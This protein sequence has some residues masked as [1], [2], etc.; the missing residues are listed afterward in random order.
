MASSIAHPSRPRQ[1]FAKNDSYHCADANFRMASVPRSRLYSM[2]LREPPKPLIDPMQTPSPQRPSRLVQLLFLAVMA[3]MAGRSWPGGLN[4]CGPACSFD[5][6]LAQ[7]VEAA[8]GDP[9]TLTPEA[10]ATD[11]SD[12]EDTDFGAV[13]RTLFEVIPSTHLLREPMDEAKSAR[14]WTNYLG[15][16]DYERL[17]F[18]QEDIDAFDRHRLTL[19]DELKAGD[20]SFAAS[21][22]AVYLQRVEER[23][24]VV[25]SLLAQPFDF[26]VHETYQWKRREAPWAANREE[27]DDLWRRRVK[28]EVLARRINRESKVQAAQATVPDTVPD[29]PQNTGMDPSKDAGADAAAPRPDLPAPAPETAPAPAQAGVVGVEDEGES[30]TDEA[31]VL[32]RYQRFLG[33]LKD[34]D[35]EDPMSRFLGAVAMAFD[36]HTSYMSPASLED[37]GINMQLSL[38]GI[39]AQ[40]RPEDGTARVVEIIPG[41]PA[42]R[43]TR[44]IRLV[45]GDRI[46]GVAQ[47]DGPMV[48]TLHWPLYK[49]VRQIRGPKG[50]KVVLLVQ[51]ASDPSGSTTKRVDLIRDEVKLEEQAATSSLETVNDTAGKPRKL[52]IIRLPTF[53]SSMGGMNSDATPRS[54]SLDI[55]RLLAELNIESIEGLVLDL[56]GNGGGALKEAIDLVGLFIRT[57]PVVLVK[58]GTRI[59]TLPDQDPAVAFRK[60][61][62]VLIDRLSASA[63]EIVAGAL[64]DYGRAIVVGDSRSHGKGTVQ[65]IL[66][67]DEDGQLGSIKIT[68]ASFYRIN[69]SSTQVRGVASDIRVPSVF[70]YFADLGEDKLPNAI[71]WTSVRAAVFRPVA[72]LVP[73]LDSLR[74]RS[75]D[76][77]ATD[78][79]WQRHARRLQRIETVQNLAAVPLQIDERRAFARDERELEE[80]EAQLEEEGSSRKDREAVRRA[81]DVVLDEG[82]RILIDFIDVH[83]PLQS[84]Q[85]PSVQP[86]TDTLFDRF[87]R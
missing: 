52:G 29:T 18:R 28:N 9:G 73:T 30:L 72:D 56:R 3:Y 31:F 25:E 79:R 13:A 34:N 45:P 21:A 47:G 4:P 24:G 33:T 39:G 82:L 14:A 22:Y 26:S 55:A 38:Q 48:D 67:L 7:T 51:P 1:A 17:Y 6:R 37:F 32:K 80:V 49:A 84:L 77:L 83:G 41:G 54:A 70:D 68:N 19:G 35:A 36:P 78:E 66:P 11:S 85:A 65:Q 50:T 81:N 2:W 57:G 27:Q 76:R 42:D 63:S 16:L 46:I 58:E 87:F 59:H 44:D 15:S 69:G 5:N 64:Q 61:M 40:L 23:V 12:A 53:Y 43:D 71:P 86:G 75:Q 20:V 60:P 10:L 74:K 62:V 8:T